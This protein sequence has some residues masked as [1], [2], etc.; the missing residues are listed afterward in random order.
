MDLP[1]QKLLFWGPLEEPS[2]LEVGALE[3]LL[4]P[5][6]KPAKMLGGPF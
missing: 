1:E 4:A 6:G 2:S 5:S 3:G